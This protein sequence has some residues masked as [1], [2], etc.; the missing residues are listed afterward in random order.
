MVLPR[1]PDWADRG[2]EY[3]LGPRPPSLTTLCAGVALSPSRPDIPKAELP[4]VLGDTP[5]SHLSTIETGLVALGVPSGVPLGVVDALSTLAL[6]GPDLG[7]IFELKNTLRGAETSSFVRPVG[8]SGPLLLTFFRSVTGVFDAGELAS[9]GGIV[10]RPA[11]RGVLAFRAGRPFVVVG[12]S[13]AIV[14]TLLS[15]TRIE[16]A[17]E[18]YASFA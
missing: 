17:F 10:P 6:L 14:T 12:F 1:R 16:D 3:N 8:V 13:Y 7:V 5:S 15:R 2:R 11:S 9:F 18:V 4:D